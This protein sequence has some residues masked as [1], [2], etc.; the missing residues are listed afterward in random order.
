MKAKARI[1]GPCRC[2]E[3]PGRSG[4]VGMVIGPFMGL[5]TLKACVMRAPIFKRSVRN[6]LMLIEKGGGSEPGVGWSRRWQE[7]FPRFVYLEK[8]AIHSEVESAGAGR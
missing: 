2:W 8:L 6:R 4:P 3:A 5:V 1:C 7:A